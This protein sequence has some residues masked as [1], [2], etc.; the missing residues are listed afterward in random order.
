MGVIDCL[1]AGY[2]YLGWRLELILIPIVLDL[3]LWLGPRLNVA[4]LFEQFAISYRSL[5]SAEGVTPEIGQMVSQL[6]DSIRQMGEGSNLLNGLISGTLL[7]VP[8]LPVVTANWLPH[9]TIDIT[10]MGEAA[11]WWLVFSLLGLLLGVIYLTLLARRLPIGSA[12]GSSGGQVA[13]AV[14][15]HWLQVI[16]FVI[17]ASL[18]LLVLYLPI[19]FIVGL[20]MLVSPAI[21]S[22][23]AALAGAITLVVFF[24]LYFVTAALI[25]DNVPLGV[26]IMR[27][28]RLVRENFWATLGFILLSSLIGLGI[29]LLLVQLANLALWAGF[30]AIVI[31]AYIGTGLSMALL[32]FYR[33][34]FIK[35]ADM[36][37]L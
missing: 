22:A 19:S 6:S 23:A 12:A 15:R 14:L 11:I 17:I 27:S 5:A 8:S 35:G 28:I 13:V 30:A 10:T 16:G 25:M 36:A 37:Q 33:S 24:Y 26:A 3:L 20:M 29:A 9:Y 31:N 18:A 21:G 2:R 34:R 7:H 4:P 32:V 1:S